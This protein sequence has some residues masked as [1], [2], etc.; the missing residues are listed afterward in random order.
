ME[1]VKWW[2]G[3]LVVRNPCTAKIFTA[4]EYAEQFATILYILI[5][6]TGAITAL[7]DSRNKRRYPVDLKQRVTNDSSWGFAKKKR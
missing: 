4:T 6:F 5:L 1:G 7:S 3:G 2:L